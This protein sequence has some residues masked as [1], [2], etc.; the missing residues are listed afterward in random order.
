MLR[1]KSSTKACSLKATEETVVHAETSKE[2]ASIR[3]EIL[4]A[5]GQRGRL[6]TST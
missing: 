2:N 6:C 5:V 3:T 4:S 1:H